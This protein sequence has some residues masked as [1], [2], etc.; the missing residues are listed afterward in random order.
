MFEVGMVRLLVSRGYSIY[1]INE[2]PRK[3]DTLFTGNNMTAAGLQPTT[4]QS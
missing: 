3:T 4:F 1:N 2:V